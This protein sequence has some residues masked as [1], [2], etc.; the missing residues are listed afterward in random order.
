MNRK[1]DGSPFDDSAAQLDKNLSRL[2][3]L[4]DDSNIP[5]KAFSRSLIDNAL[6]ELERLE[7]QTKREQRHK[8]IQLNW[9]KKVMGWA[10]MFAAACGAGLVII[11]STLLKINTFLAVIVLLYHRL[12]IS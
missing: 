12:L 1:N 7:C 5:S 11:L 9:P 10:A 2:V 6:G 3:K 8:I 4:A